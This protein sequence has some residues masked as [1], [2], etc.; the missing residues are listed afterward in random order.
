LA[1][2]EDEEVEEGSASPQKQRRPFDEEGYLKKWDEDNAKIDIPP[3]VVDY[4]DNDYDLEYDEK[5]E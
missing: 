3:D 4:I 1:L 2:L 5:A